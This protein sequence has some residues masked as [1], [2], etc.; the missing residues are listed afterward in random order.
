[1]AEGDA[2]Q[3]T[4]A[5]EDSD[6][7]E[8]T[9]TIGETTSAQVRPAPDQLPEVDR[10]RYVVGEHV[11]SGGEG[12]IHVAQ[13]TWLGRIV[14]LKRQ[15]PDRDPRAQRRF[16]R[17][18]LL[19][20]RLQHPSIVPVYEAGRWPDGDPFY[21]MKLVSGQSLSAELTR[22]ATLAE[23]LALLPHVL[24]VAEA[25]AYAHSRGVIHR[26]L[27]PSNVLVGKFGE[28]VVIDWG[29]GKEL[30]D[31]DGSTSSAS[32]SLPT[33]SLGTDSPTTAKREPDDG[34]AML[35]REG[36]VI[37]TPA[38]MPPEQARGRGVGPAAD[39][40]A[41][42]AM[43]YHLLTGHPPYGRGTALE[44]LGRVL[45]GPPEPLSSLVPR[46]PRELVA[47]VTKAMAREPD[48]RYPTAAAFAEDLRRF[49]TGQIVG[50]H[51][52]TSWQ[53]LR[54]WAWRHRTAL[55]TSLAALLVLVV[56]GIYSVREL[57]L[58]VAKT[59]AEHLEVTKAQRAAML[60]TEAALD[61][62][63]AL[64][65]ESARVAAQRDP[66][67]ALATLTALSE[68]YRQ[69]SRVQV[70]AAD[71]AAHGLAT[72]LRPCA[73]APPPCLPSPARAIGLSADLEVLGVDGRLVAFDPEGGRALGPVVPAHDL[74]Q[75][76]RRGDRLV[77]ADASGQLRIWSVTAQTSELLATH[78]GQLARLWLGEG[79]VVLG[80]EANPEAQDLW[81]WA[82]GQPG[83]A[84]ERCDKLGEQRRAAVALSPDHRW[85]GCLRRD[86]PLVL[87]DLQTGQTL[88]TMLEKLPRS[89]AVSDGARWV[90]WTGPDDVVVVWD[91]VA[92]QRHPLRRLDGTT[93]PATVL[94]F[95]PSLG[96]D[97]PR[98]IA[99]G[100][101][102]LVTSWT[103]G[104]TGL[105]PLSS[106]EASVLSLQISD[107][108][109]LLATAALDGSVHLHDLESSTVRR[110]VGFGSLA[111]RVCIG[112]TGA[113]VAAQGLDDTVRAW[114][115]DTSH[116]APVARLP[117]YARHLVMDPSGARLLVAGEV[118]GVWLVSLDE[119]GAAEPRRLEGLDDPVTALA[120]G[121]GGTRVAAG[122]GDG[123]VAVWGLDGQR[124]WQDRVADEQIR[125][126][127]LS[128]DDGV[129]AVAAY[130][131]GLRWVHLPSGQAVQPEGQRVAGVE[132]LRDGGVLAW[133]HDGWVRTWT[134]D[135][136]PRLHRE[137]DDE[138][139]IAQVSPT[140]DAVVF[141]GRDGRLRRLTLPEGR[142]R[143]ATPA[144]L[145][146]TQ[147]HHLDDG[148]RV[149][150]VGNDHRIRLWDAATLEQQA[151]FQGHRG[152]VTDLAVRGA[153]GRVASA[154]D[155]GTAR[156]WDLAT[157]ESRELVGHRGRLAA[158]EL[159]P[160]G[161][162]VYTAGE[163]GTVRRWDPA[164]PEQ[165]ARLR[166]H[167]GKVNAVAW[168]PGGEWL[169]SAGY[170]GTVRVWSTSMA[171]QLASLDGHKGSVWSV[172]WDPDGARLASAG[173]DGVVRL[174]SL[175]ATAVEAELE[176]HE[177]TVWSVAWSGARLASAGDDGNIRLWSARPDAVRSLA[178]VEGHEG[179][180]NAVAWSSDGARL[181]SVGDDGVIQLWQVDPDGDRID[182]VRGLEGQPGAL[183]AVAWSGD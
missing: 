36:A 154:S 174:W 7:D 158:I 103:P 67:A 133:S 10:E 38:Y 20:A 144:G 4:L 142:E 53:R 98:L 151:L 73:Q 126:L 169:A 130:T 63:D 3:A 65:I 132:V 102:G 94:A 145:D 35:T 134:S 37:G 121:P 150:T 120:F 33:A 51:R 166:G 64:R 127:S 122:S 97:P 109:R 9:D 140:G 69:W 74:R 149:L 66:N 90:A 44:V 165:V 26:D 137:Y 82:P 157:G 23:R 56:G 59:K 17:E 68:R 155:D 8:A 30:G 175:R 129:L 125:G 131:A 95:G 147:V 148:A 19:T 11:A 22:A 93:L 50:A 70:I 14:A 57:Q 116:G 156:L 146:I 21:A 55:S 105:H 107:D 40:Y 114:A 80:L 153:R 108:G 12:S 110:F 179:R 39:V 104:Q 100:Y 178:R 101:D 89:V 113:V 136:E 48:E 111:F 118:G 32:L 161:R 52:Y 83:R 99:A 60:A 85:A 88:E 168:S 77:T 115:L 28:T 31:L 5:A 162:F 171:R 79:G 71:A 117:G 46:A 180:I 96:A 176:G 18:A 13:D 61:Q 72:V 87:H 58:E 47:I 27:K 78:P 34:D 45:S 24:D 119:P 152:Y 29:L 173:D 86:G 128:R 138:I 41:L 91:V 25:I 167:A 182:R 54:R 106:H 183:W 2:D 172:A 124:Q 92:D 1:M 164:K 181:A 16:V 135:G 62:A 49:Q 112:P 141:A 160:D 76:A 159:S 143:T 84:L 123:V 6:D 163:D 42:G 139:W 177:G 170:D 81:R 15:H 75:F 43:L